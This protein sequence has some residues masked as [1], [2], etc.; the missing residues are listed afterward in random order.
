[1]RLKHLPIFNIKP[2]YLERNDSR[3]VIKQLI[4]NYELAIEGEQMKH[5]V[6]SYTYDCLNSG[7]YIFSLKNLV[8]NSET[9][10]T[11]EITMITIEVNKNRIRQKLGELNRSCNPLEDDLI[12][13]WANQHNLTL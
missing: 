1:L 2:Y 6:F 4:T 10:K 13:E 9:K 8:K 5:C 12:E 7:T 11:R 3:Y